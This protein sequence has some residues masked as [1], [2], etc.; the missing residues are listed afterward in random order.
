MKKSMLIGQWK[1]GD[2]QSQQMESDMEGFSEEQK[3][4][5][6]SLMAETIF[7]YTF[8]FKEDGTYQNNLEPSIIIFET[9]KTGRWKIDEEGKK[10]TILNKRGQ[11]T[12]FT[13]TE[14]GETTMTLKNDQDTI[15]FV[16]V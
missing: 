11:E 12:V 14:S 5:V 9:A 1:I 10:F 16:K 13:I 15:S 2:M 3:K 7:T 4:T 8:E 6:A